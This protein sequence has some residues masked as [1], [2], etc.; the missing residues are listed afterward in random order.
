MNECLHLRKDGNHDE[1]SN[2]DNSI[3]DSIIGKLREYRFPQAVIDDTLMSSTM[4]HLA[5]TYILLL[6][7]YIM[8]E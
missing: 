4:N 1:F 6:H 5:A 8:K 2:F 7:K 3:L